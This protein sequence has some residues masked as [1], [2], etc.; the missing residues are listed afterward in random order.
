MDIQV[1]TRHI[2]VAD[3]LQAEITE[4]MDRLQR[5][6]EKITSC[7]VILD[8]E[9]ADKTVEIV[10]SI[11]GRRLTAKAKA[12]NIRV[13]LE[14]AVGKVERQLKRSKERVKEHKALRSG[15]LG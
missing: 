14:D 9:R 1:T 15:D 5:F 8:S 11:M 4:K 13:A 7:R 12:D 2:K 10:M 6:F 3:D